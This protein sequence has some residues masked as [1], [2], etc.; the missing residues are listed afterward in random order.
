M[1]DIVKVEKSIEVLRPRDE[2]F[3]IFTV[4][5]ASWWPTER[6][7]VGAERVTEIQFEERVGG[8]VF[9]RWDDGTECDWA[10]VTVWDPPSKVGLD[11]SPSP[12]VDIATELTITF[13]EV[14]SGTRVELVHEGWER[15]GADALESRESYHTGWDLV[16]TRFA[17]S[18]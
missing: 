10:I 15:L 12:D 1:T 13:I 4:G 16:L 6:H 2:A 5:I 7:S 17:E 3:K 8:R 11:W 14:D 18:A 9:E